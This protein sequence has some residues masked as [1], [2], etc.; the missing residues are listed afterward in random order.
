MTRGN[1][2]VRL[3]ALEDNYQ[4]FLRIHDHIISLTELDPNH[5]YFKMGFCELVEDIYFDNKAAFRDFNYILDS[6]SKVPA[7]PAAPAQ[8]APGPIDI[9]ALLK[10]SF[11]QSLPQIDI[12]KFSGKHSEWGNFEDHFRVMIHRREDLTSVMK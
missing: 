3:Q 1:A 11:A 4:D 2:E 7:D 9:E 8:A 12:P 10:S 5:E 6:Q